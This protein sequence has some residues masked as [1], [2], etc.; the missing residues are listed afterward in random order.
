MLKTT[1]L[2]IVSDSRVDDNEVVGGDGI[3]AESGESVVK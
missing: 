2:F 3:G 1:E